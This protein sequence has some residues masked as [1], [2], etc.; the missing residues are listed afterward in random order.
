MRDCREAKF[1]TN[2]IV[3]SF[4]GEK[5]LINLAPKSK[6]SKFLNSVSRFRSSHRRILLPSEIPGQGPEPTIFR[7]QLAHP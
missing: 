6:N 4:A 3:C 2:D 1:L 7:L 5:R